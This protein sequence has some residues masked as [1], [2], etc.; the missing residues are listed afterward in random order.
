MGIKL[1]LGC[2]D[3]PVDG[4]VNTDITPH[5]FV[6]RVPGLAYVLH[7]LGKMDAQRLS[8]HREGIFRRVKYLDLTK[9][10]PFPDSSVT[11]IFSSHVLEH[12]F[13]REAE[14]L[15]KECCRVLEPAGVCRVVVPDL[16]QVVKSYGADN[17]N[18]FLR[19]IFEAAGRGNIKN[20]H[21]WGYTGNSLTRLMKDC[22]FQNAFVRQ[23]REGQC[24]DLQ[25]LDNRPEYSIYVE[26]LSE[27]S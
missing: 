17:P 14:S 18:E 15:L 9:P 8:Q 13:P 25:W 4:W 12:L 10:L 11:A 27:Y 21:H 2:F 16:D 6:A 7:K 5:I 20:A 22:G 3:Q 24:P 1:H 26:G 19:S 23:N